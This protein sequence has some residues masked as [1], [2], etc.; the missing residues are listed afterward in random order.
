MEKHVPGNDEAWRGRS[1]RI[2]YRLIGGLNPEVARRYGY[3]VD[4]DDLGMT[5]RLQAAI[6]TR[7]W[8]AVV[9]TAQQLLDR[10]HRS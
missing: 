10:K 1:N 2:F 5:V 8:Q 3:A 6:S 9:D 7:G 4:S